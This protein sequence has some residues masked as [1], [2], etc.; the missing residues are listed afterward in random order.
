MADCTN[1]SMKEA[2]KI[3]NN[4]KSGGHAN[5]SNAKLPSKMTMTYHSGINGS[6][7]SPSAVG[8]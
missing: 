5:P 3:G 7:E 6:A 2:A 4:N 8:S 1:D